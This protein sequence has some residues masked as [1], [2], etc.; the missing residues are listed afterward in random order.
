MTYWRT[1][2]QNTNN[3]NT[4]RRTAHYGYFLFLPPSPSFHHPVF[5]HS[6]SRRERAKNCFKRVVTDGRIVRL[7]MRKASAPI[8]ITLFIVS[9]GHD[10]FM[11]RK[12]FYDRFEQVFYRSFSRY[13]TN[14]KRVFLD[15]LIFLHVNAPVSF[16][17]SYV[18]ND[19]LTFFPIHNRA[20]RFKFSAVS[21]VRTV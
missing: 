17:P 7:S 10:A 15:L 1:C 12:F 16:R 8:T 14:A 18:F 9:G 13:Q 4:G 11:R 20:V 3:N 6:T 5:P 21:S 2:T 19:K